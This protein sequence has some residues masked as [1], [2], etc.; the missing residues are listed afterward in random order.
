MQRWGGFGHMG[1]MGLWWILG[2]A[3]L[4]GLVWALGAATRTR[5]REETPEL[6]LKRRLARGEISQEEYERSLKA[7]RK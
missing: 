2:L 1:W 4:I 7:L 3:L 6:I 5:D